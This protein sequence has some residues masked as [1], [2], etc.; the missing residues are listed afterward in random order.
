MYDGRKKK[1]Y[2][3]IFML[4]NTKQ[5]VKCSLFFLI[6]LGFNAYLEIKLHNKDY[7]SPLL[8]KAMGTLFSLAVRT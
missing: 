7:V 6:V 1:V 3:H 5:I 8:H 4:K 2:R